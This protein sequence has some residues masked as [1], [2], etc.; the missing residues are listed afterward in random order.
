MDH[1]FAILRTWTRLNSTT[2]LNWDNRE[3]YY[4][5]PLCAVIV[6]GAS[7]REANCVAG[8]SCSVQDVKHLFIHIQALVNHCLWISHGLARV[9]PECSHPLNLSRMQIV[10]IPSLWLS[11]LLI[12]FRS[13]GSSTQLTIQ[14]QWIKETKLGCRFLFLPGIIIELILELNDIIYKNNQIP[15][16]LI[17]YIYFLKQTKYL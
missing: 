3:L 16:V 8:F 2:E 6:L 15:L 11:V 17:L 4:R 14:V 13:C 1:L 10:N 5:N 9:L 12:S 7:S